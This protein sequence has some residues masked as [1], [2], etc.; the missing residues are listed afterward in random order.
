MA[1]VSVGGGCDGCLCDPELQG[2]IRPWKDH[3]QP[4][5][6]W[7]VV[8]KGSGLS[9]QQLYVLIKYM[10]FTAVSE[11]LRKP[12]ELWELLTNVY[13]YQVVT[14]DGQYA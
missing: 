1:S 8:V 13:I 6:S 11:I 14:M 10:N 5:Q 12:I 3:C 4:S 2:Q 9:V 7:S